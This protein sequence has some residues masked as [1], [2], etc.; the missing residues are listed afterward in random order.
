MFTVPAV[1]HLVF[2]PNVS[3]NP[4]TGDF[5]DDDATREWST[6]DGEAGSH[7]FTEAGLFEVSSG[8]SADDVLE[9]HDRLGDYEI[10]SLLGSGGMGQVFLAEHVRMQRTVA[11]KTLPVH[12]LGDAKAIER[13]FSE[14]RAASRV[15]HPNIVT[16]FDAGEQ[17]GVPYLAMEYV[18]GKTLT[19]IV[20]E[21]GPLTVGDAADVI[22]Q[23]A[24]GLLHAHRAGVVHRDVKPGN[25]MRTTDG[26]VK[27]L[28]LGLAQISSLAVDA[29]RP[30]AKTDAGTSAA[31]AKSQIHGDDKTAGKKQSRGKRRP[32]KLIGTLSFMSPEQLEDPESIDSRSDIYSLGATLYFLLTGRTPYPGEFLDQVYGHRHGEIPDLMQIRDDVDMNFANVFRRMMAKSPGARYNSLDEVIED[33]SGYVASDSAPSWLQQLAPMQAIAQD[34]STIIGGSTYGGES[35]VARRTEIVGLDLGMF[36]LAAASADLSGSLRNLTPGELGQPLFR[37]VMTGSDGTMRFG[38][39]ATQRQSTNPD[40]V[41]RCLPMYFGQPTIGRQVCGRNCPP[42]VLMGAMIRRAMRQAWNRKQ[43]PEAV[44][45]TVPSIYDQLHRRSIMQSATI[46]GLRSV[47][48]VDRSLACVQLMMMQHQCGGTAS[49][50]TDD[51]PLVLDDPAE[52]E[53]MPGD[54]SRHVLFVGLTG[55]ACEAVVVRCENGRLEQLGASGHWNHGTLI[56]IQRLVDLAAEMYSRSIDLDPRKTLRRAARLQTACER[57][58]QSLIMLPSVKITI[59]AAS[60]PVSVVV[61]RMQWMLRCEDLI[62]QV[63]EHI[64]QACERA[65]IRP[66]EVDHVVGLGPLLRMP[67]LKKRIFAGVP[68]AA[69]VTMADRH[70]VACGAAICLSGELPG[71]GDIPMPPRNVASQQIGVLV[72]DAQGRSRILPIIPRGT[73]LPART[74]RRISAGKQKESLT[75]SLVESSGPL[76]KHWQSLG[77][78][79]FDLDLAKDSSA[80]RARMIGFEV[81]INGLLTVRAQTPGVP[82]SNKLPSLPKPAI[83]ESDLAGW[84]QWLNEQPVE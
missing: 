52:S 13:F 67:E 21:G 34:S 68:A 59:E 53:P 71:R 9:V 63:T 1:I 69:N 79:D 61:D 35:T 24:L 39:V 62:D 16:A 22:R 36:D 58:I 54:E 47:R 4:P 29:I 80:K 78:Y 75:L 42:E 60:H 51:N 45:I 83:D 5:R 20:S 37:M 25:L 77:Q 38:D 3:A 8:D 50:P 40:Q 74:N 66:D 12:R 56:W 19:Q 65:S 84:I 81:D 73:I 23:A 28:D 41:I 7:D 46:A 49:A 15:M 76:G 44:A 70:D 43:P 55:Q 31:D 26:T 33:L 72:E 27:V 64:Q 11:L 10:K 17:D 6:G 32:G 57:A 30:S 18:D 2:D 14:V 48:L 82:G